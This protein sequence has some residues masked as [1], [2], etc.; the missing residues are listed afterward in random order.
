MALARRLAALLVP[1]LLGQPRAAQGQRL[2]NAKKAKLSLL[3]L[4]LSSLSVLMTCSS[5]LPRN[6]SGSCSSVWCRLI[7]ARIALA[8]NSKMGIVA[9]DAKSAGA[10][11]AP[12]DA[13]PDSDKAG[14]GA[15]DDNDADT[16]AGD[17]DSKAGA[18]ASSKS[19][20]LVGFGDGDDEGEWITP[21]NVHQIQHTDK[22][23]DKEKKGYG[24]ESTCLFRLNSSSGYCAV[25]L[26]QALLL[27][28]CRL[29]RA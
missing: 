20:G 23:K 12:A 14:A 29:W 10:A 26:G 7:V 15:D 2:R 27:P 24:A 5:C 3:S 9:G 19:A 4:D 25:R 22:D 13:K 8:V 1:V 16:A 11:A 18:A 28:V 21:D 6:V 17:G